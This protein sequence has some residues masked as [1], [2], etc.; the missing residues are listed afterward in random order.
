MP[1]KAHPNNPIVI[2]LEQAQAAIRQ[3][4]ITDLKDVREVRLRPDKVE[5]VRYRLD[6]TGGRIF[7]ADGF[8]T[9]DSTI[10]VV[11]DEHTDPAL[12]RPTAEEQ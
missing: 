5:V 7:I 9:D 4:G 1:T 12:S 10:P 2:G 3:L 8:L 11:V 6:E